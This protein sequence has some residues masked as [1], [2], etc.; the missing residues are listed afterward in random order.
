MTTAVSIKLPSESD[1]TGL[2][3]F[4]GILYPPMVGDPLVEM[5]LSGDMRTTTP[6]GTIRLAVEDKVGLTA[7]D[8]PSFAG[9]GHVTVESTGNVFDMI[10]ADD[11]I[12]VRAVGLINSTS[13]LNATIY[14]RMRQTGDTECE[15]IS[16]TCHDQHGNVVPVSDCYPAGP[17]DTVAPCENYMG[18]SSPATKAGVNVLGT[19]QAH[20]TSWF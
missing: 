8:F 9:T 19:F 20:Y 1:L 11:Q 6:A 5:I 16:Y 2:E 18:G 15:A 10:F 3:N 4:F 14:Y 7:R 12:V 17:P 13:T